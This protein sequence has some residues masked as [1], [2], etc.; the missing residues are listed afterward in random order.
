MPNAVIK[1]HGDAKQCLIGIRHVAGLFGG[2]VSGGPAT[3]QIRV[4]PATV[5]PKLVLELGDD[6]PSI[7]AQIVLTI[8]LAEM[9]GYGTQTQIQ[10]APPLYYMPNALGF[11]SD[12]VT[13]FATTLDATLNAQLSNKRVPTFP[14][15]PRPPGQ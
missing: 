9:Q 2:T 3:L 12:A 13:T 10:S 14:A 4:P 8:G 11:D 5:N 7:D 6:L 1:T 15:P